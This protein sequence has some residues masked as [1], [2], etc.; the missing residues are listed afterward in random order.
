MNKIISVPEAAQKRREV[1]SGVFP[2]TPRTVQD[3]EERP[4]EKAVRTE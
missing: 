4:L 1:L 2:A 3:W